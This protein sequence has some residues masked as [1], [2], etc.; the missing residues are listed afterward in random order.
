MTKIY[1]VA[2]MNRFENDDIARTRYF[3][4]KEKAIKYA[5]KINAKYEEARANKNYWE[6]IYHVD[7]DWGIGEITADEEE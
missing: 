2:V 4:T 7:M 1:T 3:T 6:M 5:E